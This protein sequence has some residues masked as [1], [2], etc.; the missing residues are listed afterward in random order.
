MINQML[1]LTSRNLFNL[2]L[3]SFT[4]KNNKI[5]DI[6]TN[7]DNRNCKFRSLTKSLSYRNKIKSNLNN[8]HLKNLKKSNTKKIKTFFS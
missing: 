4:D 5:K 6:Y 2:N 8:K 1:K 7:N 3:L